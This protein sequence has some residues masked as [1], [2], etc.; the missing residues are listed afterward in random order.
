MMLYPHKCNPKDKACTCMYTVYTCKYMYIQLHTNVCTCKPDVR[1]CWTSR[2]CLLLM[3][4]SKLET[5]AVQGSLACLALIFTY[6][7]ACTISRVPSKTT[8]GYIQMLAEPPHLKSPSEILFPADY[9]GILH[10]TMKV[11][12]SSSSRS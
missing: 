6:I 10:S 2:A 3:R 5:A 4:A 11:I 9:V 7:H 8:Q 12:Q 1:G